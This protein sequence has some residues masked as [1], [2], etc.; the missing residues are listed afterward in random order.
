MWVALSDSVVA[1]SISLQAADSMF[2]P[3]HE[4]LSSAG[5]GGLAALLAAVIVAIILL[6]V[7]RRTQKHHAL[8]LEELEGYHDKT[9]ADQQ[10]DAALQRCWRRLEW[11]VDTAG[12]EPASSQGV[13]LGLG[14]ELA[15]EVLRGILRQAE[16]LGDEE[17]G[18]AA[19]VHLSQLSLV[20]AQQSGPLISPANDA[21][22]K[23]T[24]PEK[25]SDSTTFTATPNSG[26]PESS[27]PPPT[28][29]SAQTPSR[30]ARPRRSGS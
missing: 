29:D 23:A 2:P 20:L 6:V 18:N 9:R 4:F 25:A 14:P 7:S 3:A 12:I 19:T 5:F 15:L 11:V 26:G 16:E 22:A 8:V 30:N 17:L 13:T 27:P 1:Q 21:A 10:R 24:A 28:D